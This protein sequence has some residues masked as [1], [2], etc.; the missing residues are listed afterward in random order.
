MEKESDGKGSE[1]NPTESID[2][3]T[4]PV[5]KMFITFLV[6]LTVFLCL[7]IL[8]QSTH[9]PFGM[10][11]LSSA[12]RLMWAPQQLHQDPLEEVVIVQ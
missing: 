9:T 11:C 10:I 6:V 4:M 3:M 8:F 7:R 2:L 1:R 12:D 5:T